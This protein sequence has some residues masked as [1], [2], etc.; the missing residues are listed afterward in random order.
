MRPCRPAVSTCPRAPRTS[1]ARTS[2]PHTSPPHASCHLP[3]PRLACPH[4]ASPPS[5][6]ALAERVLAHRSIRVM[7]NAS[8]TRFEGA[9][10]ALTHARVRTQ[11]PAADGSGAL[12]L[13]ETRLEVRDACSPS[14]LHSAPHSAPHFARHAH[15]MRPH[16]MCTLRA[17]LQV[18]AAFVS[19]GHD[20]NTALFEGQLA[21][22]AGGSLQPCASAAVTR[23]SPG[24]SLPYL[25]LHPA[26][27]VRCRRGRLPRHERQRP[28]RAHERG[29]RLRG[30]RRR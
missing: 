2:P 27:C 9:G 24:C 13:T 22:G 6:R 4:P 25:R 5:G 23:C 3:T 20:P 1:P 17:R 7:W 16:P 30:R 21:L 29:W 28:F 15:D 11:A 8:V 12:Q 10:G 18:S 26:C 19:I 14:P